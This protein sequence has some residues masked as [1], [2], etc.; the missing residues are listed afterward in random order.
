MDQLAL[1]LKRRKCIEFISLLYEVGLCP[2]RKVFHKSNKLTPSTSRDTSDFLIFVI[3]STYFV[4]LQM[5][6]SLD[7]GAMFVSVLMKSPNNVIR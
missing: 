5:Y 2:E 4:N 7:Q 6:R 3:L 1:Q